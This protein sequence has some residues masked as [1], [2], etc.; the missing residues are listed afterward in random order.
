MASPSPPTHSIHQSKVICSYLVSDREISIKD[1]K[2]T[3][4]KSLP[5]YMIPAFIMQLPA[6]P[7][8]IIAAVLNQGDGSILWQVRRHPP[9]VRQERQ[10][11]LDTSIKQSLTVVRNIHQ[12]KVICSYLVSDREISIKDLKERQQGIGDFVVQHKQ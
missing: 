6:F 3:L 5:S 11:L 1:L 12:S 4:A 9:I 10:I 2:A 7:L 8:N